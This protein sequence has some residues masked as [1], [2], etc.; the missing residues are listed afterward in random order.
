MVAVGGSGATRERREEMLRTNHPNQRRCPFILSTSRESHLRH[1]SGEHMLR[2]MGGWGGSHWLHR[3]LHDL[4]R[5]V[6]FHTQMARGRIKEKRIWQFR[7]QSKV[8]EFV[9]LFSSWFYPPRLRS[10][11]Q[12]R[13]ISP[14]F[15]TRRNSQRAR[16]AQ[17]KV[18]CGA[19]RHS[20]S[21]ENTT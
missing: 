7:Y 2:S 13:M 11:G 19:A 16:E 14:C 3:Q 17:P 10:P 21:D 6:T 20:H 5:S 4:P 9:L 1:H 18:V 15:V 12:W 8:I